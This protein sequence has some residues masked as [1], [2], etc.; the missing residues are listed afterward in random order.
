[1]FDYLILL[2][3][4]YSPQGNNDMTTAL[5]QSGATFDDTLLRLWLHGRSIHTQRAY[6]RDATLLLD[7]TGKGL[8]ELT[9]ADLHAFADN[10]ADYAPST[11]ARI[12]ASVKSLLSF[13]HEKGGAILKEVL[14][15]EGHADQLHGY[16]NGVHVNAP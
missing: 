12:I 6:T 5:A 11:Q 1:M 14:V 13:A 3:N 2:L 4:G 16:R 8:R 15:A 7:V 10:I 9:F